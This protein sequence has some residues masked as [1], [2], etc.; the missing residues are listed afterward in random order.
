MF[1]SIN[2]SIYLL[3]IW[4][5]MTGFIQAQDQ[6]CMDSLYQFIKTNSA[7]S[8]GV[9]WNRVDSLYHKLIQNKTN[10]HDSL[11]ALTGILEEINDHS[12]YFHYKND[13]ISVSG[14]LKSRHGDQE[15]QKRAAEEKDKILRMKFNRG[16]AYL[17]LSGFYTNDSTKKHK[18]AQAIYDSLVLYNPVH[19]KAYLLDL[20]LL[21]GG[22]LE[23][24]LAGL[25]PL[26]GEGI[27]AKESDPSGRIVHTWSI[28]QNALLKDE[29]ILYQL[30]DRKLHGYDK[31]PLVLL[32]G[33]MTSNAGKLVAIACKRRPGSL[34]IGESTS[35][36]FS[37]LISR[38]DFNNDLQLYLASNFFA[39]RSNSV[40]PDH[41]SPDQM[42]TG[43]DKFDRLLFDKKV[44][45]A[46]EWIAK[47]KL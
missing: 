16:V 42:V 6:V 5:L 32:I 45:A 2:T 18:I 33:P 35:D 28:K 11:Y 12:S 21:S 41:L 9:D 27:F 25:I 24:V 22:Q 8:R 4:V 23:P 14:K 43:G 38:Y 30:T 13:R 19:V 15:L 7:W 1:K 31:K 36:D 29:E 34:L 17:R 47:V 26:L 39:D 37:G 44:K 46:F 20:R 3:A 40:Y 10:Y